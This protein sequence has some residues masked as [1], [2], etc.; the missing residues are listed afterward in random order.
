ME[1]SDIF[2]QENEPMIPFQF[3]WDLAFILDGDEDLLIVG[4]LRENLLVEISQ[5][6]H[7]FGSHG[8][9]SIISKGLI[10][11]HLRK[12]NLLKIRNANVFKVIIV[13]FAGLFKCLDRFCRY[14]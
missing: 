11:L 12:I 7:S 10:F 13:I 2:S 8:H 3:R 6:W 5:G 14:D 4:Q 9:I 1:I